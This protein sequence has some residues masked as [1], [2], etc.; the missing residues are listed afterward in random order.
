MNKYEAIALVA[1]KLIES[2]SH[3]TG[4]ASE[5]QI[6]YYKSS[7]DKLLDVLVKDSVLEAAHAL[8]D[9]VGEHVDDGS[10]DMGI[11]ATEMKYWPNFGWIKFLHHETN[12]GK[13]AAIRTG[14]KHATGD[15]V[16]IQD[17]DGELDPA[18][19]PKLVAEYE[20][21]VASP[22]LGELVIYGSRRAT[23]KLSWGAKLINWLT[24]K[25]LDTNLTDVACGYKLFNG[26]LL[27]QIDTKSNGFS[28]CFEVTARLAAWGMKIVEVPV[29]YRPR[30]EGKKLKWW[31]GFGCLYALLKYRT[32]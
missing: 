4:D 9:A 12:L 14:L 24:N 7:I 23:G 13:G 17:A 25:Y 26:V 20:K 10:M 18:D 5:D 11:E 19:I 1:N 8:N 3:A 6:P 27:S 31:D 15:L 22:D 29:S 32:V 21:N 30:K 2:L 16:I 28:W